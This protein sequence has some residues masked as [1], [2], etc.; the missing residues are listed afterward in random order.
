[1]KKKINVINNLEKDFS[2]ESLES[3]DIELKEINGLNSNDY[4]GFYS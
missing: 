4:I 1:M 3:V 2:K